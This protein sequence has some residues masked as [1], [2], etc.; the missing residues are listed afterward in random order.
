MIAWWI[1][2]AVVVIGLCIIVG[3]LG[4]KFLPEDIFY[5]TEEEKSLSATS[6]SLPK[7]VLAS[8]QDEIPA[9][10]YLHGKEENKLSVSVI[11]E[12]AS[13]E[14]ALTVKT[15]VNDYSFSIPKKEFK[16]VV[17]SS[18]GEYV[19]SDYTL[20]STGEEITL[21]AESSSKNP[22]LTCIINK[23]DMKEKV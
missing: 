3:Y 16:T 12:K 14:Y 22:Q 17:D 11:L 5:N 7:S 20:T 13:T 15:R 19:G 21:E 4:M 10:A 2:C 9:E 18:E 1:G 6:V 8:P 23:T